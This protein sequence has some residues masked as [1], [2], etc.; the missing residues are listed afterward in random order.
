MKLKNLRAGKKWPK[1]MERERLT[2]TKLLLLV[3]VV[4]GGGGGGGGG[5]NPI[6]KISSSKWIIFLQGVETKHV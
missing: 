4:V 6:L 2:L 3:V 1:R 5:F